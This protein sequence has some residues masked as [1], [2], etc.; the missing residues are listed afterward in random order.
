[1]PSVGA[2]HVRPAPLAGPRVVPR[3]PP[4]AGVA[5]GSAS[6]I[7]LAVASIG[8]L[9]PRIGFTGRVHSTF[10]QACNLVCNDRLLT[11]A[12]HAIGDGPAT[13]RL[14]AGGPADLREWLEIGERVDCRKGVARMRRIELSLL[15]ARVWRPVECRPLLA[16]ARI[17]AHLRS[18]QA[19]LAQRRG[20]APSVIDAAAAA[21]GEACRALDRDQAARQVDRLVGWGEGL[22]PAGDDFLVGLLAGLDALVGDVEARRRFRCALAA[23]VGVRTSRTTAIA[24]NYLSL[25]RAGHYNAPLVEVRAA[26]LCEEDPGVVDA[27]LQRALA[28]GA[29]SGADTVGGLLAGLSAWLAACPVATS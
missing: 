28:V 14:A 8:C 12:A 27:A 2:L 1:M 4:L 15:R 13:L 11:I 20:T 26:L 25:A 24:A 17:E 10:A 19:R 23:T 16:G 6:Q 22:T 29:T 18:A 5:S 21:L 3:A 7:A 9:V